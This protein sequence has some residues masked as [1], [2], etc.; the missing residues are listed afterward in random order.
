MVRLSFKSERY[1]NGERLN[2]PEWIVRI[3]IICLK[4]GLLQVSSSLHTV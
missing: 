4:S 2:L 1:F 3:G